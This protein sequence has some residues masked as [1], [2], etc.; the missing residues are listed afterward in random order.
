MINGEHY[1]TA[2]DQFRHVDYYRAGDG[3]EGLRP[4]SPGTNRAAPRPYTR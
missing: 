2:Q 4:Q 3:Y 1:H